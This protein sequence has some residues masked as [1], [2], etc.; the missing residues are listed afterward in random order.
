MINFI[1]EV[2]EETVPKDLVDF[3]K[4]YHKT[5]RFCKECAYNVGGI[6]QIYEAI[7]LDDEF[8]SSSLP[9]M[10]DLYPHK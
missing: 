5:M 9:K 2:D 6:C 1:V 3:F 4:K 8:C 7:V 10:K